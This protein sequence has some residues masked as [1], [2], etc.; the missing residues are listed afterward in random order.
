[1]PKRVVPRAV[2]AAQLCQQVGVGKVGGGHRQRITLSVG[3]IWSDGLGHDALYPA[4]TTPY[5]EARV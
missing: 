4:S 2:K 1:M 3:R 5:E